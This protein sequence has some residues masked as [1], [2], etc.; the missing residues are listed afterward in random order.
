MPL[1]AKAAAA[2]QAEGGLTPVQGPL[3]GMARIRWERARDLAKAGGLEEAEQELKEA[4]AED[5]GHPLPRASLAGIYLRRNRL[6]EARLLAEAILRETPHYFRALSLLGE[7]L[8]R[9]NRPEEALDC[10]RQAAGTA[11]G[12]YLSGRMAKTLRILKRP[13]EALEI[14]DAG[15]QKDPQDARLLKEKA[16]SLKDLGREPEA[17][18]VYEKLRLI[19]PA[20]EFV[21]REVIRLRAAGRDEQAVLAELKKVANLSFEK[22]NPQIRGLYA[23][24]LKEAGQHAE[25]AEAYHEAWQLQPENYYFLK[26]EGYCRKDLGD[27]VGAIAC[28][29]QAFREDPDDYYLKTALRKL[30]LSSGKAAEFISLLE[31]LVERYPEKKKLLG[32]LKSLRKRY[33]PPAGDTGGKDG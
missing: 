21:R 6:A 32:T 12:S 24:R 7:I 26:M 15:L 11:A 20:D 4:V 8:L 29:S 27:S 19:A 14:L 3:K 17:L 18:E 16:H 9:E 1:G 5:P 28:L 23:Q 2:E 22:T 33:P 30:Y 25:A 10:F 31:E 13:A